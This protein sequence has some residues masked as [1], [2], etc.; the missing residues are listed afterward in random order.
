MM[1]MMNIDDNGDDNDN[2]MFEQLNSDDDGRTKTA[3]SV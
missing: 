3:L 1:G 2:H